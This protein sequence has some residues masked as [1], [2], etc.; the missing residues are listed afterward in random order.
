MGRENLSIDQREQRLISDEQLISALR[1]RQMRDLK[2]LHEAQIATADG[3]R[4]MSEW[5]AGRLDVGLDTARSLVRTMRRLQERPDLEELLAEGHASFDRIEAAS[6]IPDPEVGLML[7]TDVAGAR[8]E[9][10]KRARISA[11]AEC[12]SADDQFLM[13]Q[14]ALDESWWKFWGGMDGPTGALVDKALTEK[15]DEIPNLPDGRT[16]NQGWRKAMAL[17]QACV[18]GE[19]PPATVTVF[20]DAQTAAETDGEA[21]I[22]IDAGANA[23]KQ[24]LEAI[25]CDSVTEVIARTEAAG[26]WTTAEIPHSSAGLETRSARQIRASVLRRRLRQQIPVGDTSSDPLLAGWS[27]RSRR[28]D[29]SLLVPSSH[30]HPPAG[31]HPLSGC[32]DRTVATQTT[33]AV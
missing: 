12:R 9:A 16:G 15:A 32:Q 22:V 29:S 23:G 8:R 20:V 3:A 2:A 7:H 33:R 10:S 17:A 31:V 30:R 19:A 11:D 21:G 5:T 26:I 27:H 25:L 4:S 13:M 28:D 18:S 24:A 14:P 6:R 1:A